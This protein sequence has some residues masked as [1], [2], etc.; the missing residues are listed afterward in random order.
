MI[1][2]TMVV[3]DIFVAA[4]DEPSPKKRIFDKHSSLADLIQRSE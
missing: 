4:L 2:F 3:R 1:P